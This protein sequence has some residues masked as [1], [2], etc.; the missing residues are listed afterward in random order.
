MSVTAVRRLGVS[1]TESDFQSACKCCAV[2]GRVLPVCD[3]EVGAG[4][5]VGFVSTRG[6]HTP[7]TRK[8]RWVDGWQMLKDQVIYNLQL[9]FLAQQQTCTTCSSL[10]LHKTTGKTMRMQFTRDDNL[11]T[12]E[13][14][15]KLANKTVRGENWRPAGWAYSVP[16][17]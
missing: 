5:W 2:Q 13:V 16:A 12:C 17:L 15:T 6:Q 1:A 11:S 7:H 3:P 4:L 10:R 14:V 8:C 9:Q